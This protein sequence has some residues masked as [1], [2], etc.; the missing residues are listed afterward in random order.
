VLYRSDN[1]AT[2]S[3][4]NRQG[5]MAK[6]LLPLSTEIQYVCE[7][8]D[9]DLAALHIPGVLNKLADILSRFKRGKDFSD[10]E[11]RDDLFRAYQEKLPHTFTIDGAA[12][13]LGTN[14][15]VP[16]FCSRHRSFTDTPLQNEHV[17]CN[18]DFEKIYEFLVHFLQCQRAAPHTTSG[19][20][21]L[22]VWADKVWWSLLRGARVLDSFAVRSNL[23]TSPDWRKLERAD[24]TF[25]FGGTRVARG[26]TNWPVVVV[27]FPALVP[28]RGQRGEPGLRHGT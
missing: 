24:G 27:Y 15:K 26:S 9:I 20:F 13:T 5:T 28:D 22:H 1:S 8:F 25:G 19:V 16:R 6:D 14:A 10:W 7:L 3:I 2:V 18:P 21:V 4:I 17:W 12:D 23:F 11:F